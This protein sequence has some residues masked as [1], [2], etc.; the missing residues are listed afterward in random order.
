MATYSNKQGR[1]QA[2]IKHKLLPRPLYKTFDTQKEAEAYC[3]P[4]EAALKK[5]IV[6]ASIQ[7]LLGEKF[8]RSSIDTVAQAIADYKASTSRRAHDLETLNAVDR[9]IGSTPIDDISRDWCLNHVRELKVVDGLTPDTIRKRIGSLRRLFDW[10]TTDRPEVTTVNPFSALPKGF[11]S[12]NGEDRRLIEMSGCEVQENVE[13]DRRLEPE[14]EKSIRLV[15]AGN[16]R[17][18]RERAPV[19]DDRIELEMLLT[20]G[21]ESAMRMREMYTLTSDQ[22]DIAKRTVFLDKT[23]NGDNR[24]V[25]LSSVAIEALTAYAKAKG[26]LFKSVRRTTRKV[27]GALLF[28]DLFDGDWDPVALKGTTARI[29][30]RFGWLFK[31]SGVADFKFHDIRHEAT[32]RIYERTALR[33]TEIARITGHKTQSML[34]R[35]LS[36]RGSDLAPKLW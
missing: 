6:P 3:V 9:A 13:R 25:P 31:Y 18:E 20:L 26:L 30:R 35:Y 32:C 36:L 12:I 17:P 34:K 19:L 7:K 22:I 28:P 33:D 15:L 29:S 10:L 27:G 8:K 11:A 5:G 1:I 4:L 23:K 21:L 16:Q 14:E 2:R 24:Q